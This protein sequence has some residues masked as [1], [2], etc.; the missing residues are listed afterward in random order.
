[1]W[2]HDSLVVILVG[3]SVTALIWIS[4]GNCPNGQQ[5]SP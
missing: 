4:Y 5:H 3:R 1:M 2:E